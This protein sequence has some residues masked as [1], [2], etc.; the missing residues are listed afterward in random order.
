MCEAQQS[1][2]SDQRRVETLTPLDIMLGIE[3][4]WF[5]CRFALRKHRV[6]SESLLDGCRITPIK[7]RY[8]QTKGSSCHGGETLSPIV[9]GPCEPG[10]TL[11]GA[12]LSIVFSGACGDSVSLPVLLRSEL[13]C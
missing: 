4:S 5:P 7:L 6:F 8:H 11:T 9:V 12:A 10:Q 1:E 3:K 2:I 13:N